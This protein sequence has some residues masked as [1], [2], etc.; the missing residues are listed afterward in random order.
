MISAGPDALRAHSAP[1]VDF[2]GHRL[3]RLL[4][5]AA[6]ITLYTCLLLLP[7]A[8]G[9][10]HPGIYLSA[11]IL[12]FALLAA[13]FWGAPSA[14]S[15]NLWLLNSSPDASFLS[16]STYFAKALALL[17]IITGYALCQYIILSVMQVPHPVLVNSGRIADYPAFWRSFSFLCFFAAVFAVARTYIGYSEHRATE[18]L[19]G[20]LI[21][22][23]V[24]ALVALSHWFYDNGKLFWVFQPQYL[25]VSERARWPFV[26]PN[27]LAH[28]LLP[29]LFLVLGK[30]ASDFSALA[31]SI[32]KRSRSGNKFLSA[33]LTS[34][35]IQ[36]K[37]AGIMFYMSTLLA[38]MLC[39]LGS[40]SRAGWIGA[41]L[42]IT[43]FLVIEKISRTARANRSNSF[44]SAPDV[45]V[46]AAKRN[47]N[48]HPSGSVSTSLLEGA[49]HTLSDF[50]VL[51]FPLMFIFGAML[52]YLFLG[53]R[54]NELLVERINYGLM[55]SKEDMRWQIFSDTLQMVR[56]HLF[57]GIG[58]GGC[59]ES[60]PRYMS[61][62]LAG[63]NPEYAHSDP[64]QFLAEMGM[65]GALPVIALAA[66]LARACFRTILRATS[67]TDKFL[68]LGLMCGWLSLLCASLFDFP[69]RVTA[70]SFYGAIYMA[71]IVYYADKQNLK[72]FTGID[73]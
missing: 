49:L 51:I 69:F 14:F 50:R 4:R 42:G 18:L 70:I 16:R 68:S 53:E 56:E 22:S 44:N 48:N 36:G 73:Q 23:L 35:H 61:A 66:L 72:A 27:H 26:N 30:L 47:R 54:G 5:R 38:I 67:S 37:L 10:V 12:V 64:L 58:L 65:L 45:T 8:F 59:A 28:F 46:K 9:G 25:F 34:S 13:M 2:L 24:V 3:P 1:D 11:Q 7:L 62:L 32:A 33:V 20:I 40:L 55:A 52:L 41:L 17:G 31:A 21:C 43:L 29:A 57:W 15:A 19:R 6:K 39:I 63:I 71:L 60:Y